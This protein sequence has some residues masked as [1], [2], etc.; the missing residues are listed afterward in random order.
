MSRGAQELFHTN[1]LGW[2]MEHHPRAMAPVRRAF[3]DTSPDG[4]VETWREHR[5][6]DLIV[7]NADDTAR[8]VVE[9]KLY[10]IPN[11]GQLERYAR[12][13]LPWSDKHGPCGAER[14]SYFLLSLMEPNFQL[15]Q[16]WSRVSY[17]ELHAALTAVPTETLG[18]DAELFDRYL[19]LVHR[20]VGLKADVD[21]R[22]DLDGPFSV[23]KTL[24][25]L[26]MK[27]FSGPLQRMRFTGLAQS[28]AEVYGAPVPLEVNLTR[29]LGLLSYR[30]DLSDTRSIGWQLQEGQLRLYVLIRDEGLTGKGDRLAAARAK[31]AQAE[32][33]D[34]VDFSTPEMV[35]GPRLT[36][37]KLDEGEWRRFAPDFVYRY[38]K[39]SEDATTRQL[40]DTLAELTAHVDH[41]NPPS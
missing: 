26:D 36:P 27:W 16:P 11:S 6:L 21:P 32:Y 31:V 5:H 18:P 25:A 14:T 34:F 22:N 24:E 19:V 12:V 2:L 7:R 37:M 17:E 13:G 9:N 40:A 33:A 15:P 8:Y 1:T 23:R 29:G 41:W 39:V 3:G 30:R 20:L 10:S 4:P 38:R 28:I 35:L